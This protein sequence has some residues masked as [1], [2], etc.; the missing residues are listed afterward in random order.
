VALLS[1][2]ELVVALDG[3]HPPALL[4]VRPQRER[5]LAHLPRDHHLP[6][7][8]LPRRLDEVPRHRRVV[9]YDQFGA[10]ARRA[11]AFLQDHGFDDVAALEGGLDE[12]ARVVDPTI[13]RYPPE[14]TDTG[15]MLRQFPRPD[16]GCLSYLAG[17][18]LTRDAVIVDPGH[19]VEPYLRALKDGPWRLVGIVET[20]THADHLAGHAEL[21]TRTEAPI[22]VGRRSPAQYPHRSLAEGDSLEVGGEAIRVLETPGHTSDHLCLRLRDKVFTGDTLLLGACGRSDLGDGD[23]TQLY[24]SLHS[25]LLALPDDVE[26]FPAHYGAHHALVERYASSIGFERATNEALQLPTLDAFVQYMSE[27]WPPKPANF[28]RIVRANLAV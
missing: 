7:S 2:P 10:Q 25:K 16:S 1:V 5:S 14:G 3:P 28:D 13:P 23:P 24:D 26:V 11:A 20:H 17:D 8:E 9:A 6:L 27:G 18:L 15:L 21:H 22:F 12:Y 4:D 19:E